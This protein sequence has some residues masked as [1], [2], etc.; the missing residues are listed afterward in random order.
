MSVIT[1]VNVFVKPWIDQVHAEEQ[2]SVR[3]NL[4]RGPI[5]HHTM[6]LTEYQDAIGNLFNDIKVMGSRDERFP[7]LAKLSQHVNHPPPGARVES[8]RRFIEQQ[9]GWIRCHYRSQ[10]HF[11][12]LAPTQCEWRPVLNALQAKKFQDFRNPL[13]HF[14]FA[15]SH[16]QGTESNL[17]PH[18]G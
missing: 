8:C 15:K 12:F 5:G 11:L 9:H 13:P 1:I 2:I 7:K 6:I 3:E 16:V 18:G 10:C 17:L 14:R 4:R